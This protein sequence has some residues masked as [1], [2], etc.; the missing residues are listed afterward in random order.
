MTITSECFRTLFSLG[1]VVV[2]AVYLPSSVSSPTVGR[3]NRVS[4][5]PPTVREQLCRKIVNTTGAPSA[6]GPYNQVQG[7][8][9]SVLI[10][11]MVQA[12]MVD[13]TLYISGQLG[14]N[15]QGSIVEGGA[16]G[17]AEQALHNLG[18]ILH[19]AGGGGVYN[20]QSVAATK[21]V[22]GTGVSD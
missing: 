17:E 16:V 20:F 3:Q 2:T 9:I 5:E 15:K 12:V 7:L 21:D 6:I 1:W 10:E 22:L 13:R 18:Q 14:M 4:M 8:S 19:A 11:E